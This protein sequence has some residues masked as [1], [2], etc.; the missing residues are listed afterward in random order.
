MTEYFFEAL[1]VYCLVCFGVIVMHKIGKPVRVISG[2]RYDQIPDEILTSDEPILLKGLVAQ[3]PVVQ[4]GLSSEDEL[5]TYL[6]AL[7]SGSKVV[8]Y[9]CDKEK[10]GRYFY[11]DDYRGLGF[12]SEVTSLDQV[13]NALAAAKESADLGSYYVGSTTV[14]E[15]LPLFREKNP[16]AI[17][18]LNPLV[19]I[20]LGN[21]SRIAAHFDAPDNLACCVAGHRTFTLFPIEQID[22]LYVG[23]IDLTPSGQMI[24]TVDFKNPDFEKHPKFK[25][26]IEHALVAQMEPGDAL[27]LPS[28]WWHHVE[29][30]DTFNVLI[31]YWWRCASS[32]MDAPINLIYH[33]ILTL[34]DLP[35]R[36]KKAWQTVLDHFIFDDQTSKYNHIPKPA[37]G[38]LGELDEMNARRIR[39]LLLNKLNR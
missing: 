11:D 15:C 1:S 35:E 14:D 27:M 7:Y 13:L 18:T 16:M 24:S 12:E 10:S 39:S 23:P 37:Q 5:I 21:A 2:I 34:R 6:K 8:L 36:E 25:Q 30:H 33:A 32:F 4:A 38:I 17:D 3:W 9:R 28:M 20:W 31:N 19:S 29:S 26:A 22:N